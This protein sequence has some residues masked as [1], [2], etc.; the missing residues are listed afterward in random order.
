MKRPRPQT[1]AVLNALLASEGEPVPLDLLMEAMKRTGRAT[2][3]GLHQT[4]AR[5]RGDGHEIVG[6]SQDGYRLLAK[7]APEPKKSQRAMR[8]C[9]G[10]CG[11]KFMSDG[12]G[13]RFCA[14]CEEL[15][16]SRFAFLPVAHGV[17]GVRARR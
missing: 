6:C 14:R 7:A 15:K 2:L 3:A 12:P 17:A 9:L 11:K 16:N 5:L 13:H 1:D 8:G 10:W 4:F